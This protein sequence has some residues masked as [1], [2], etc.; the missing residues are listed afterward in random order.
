MAVSDDWTLAITSGLVIVGVAYS[1]WW[2]CPVSFEKELPRIQTRR[3]IYRLARNQKHTRL[4]VHIATKISKF[5]GDNDLQTGPELRAIATKVK[6]QQHKDT[7]DKFYKSTLLPMA[8]DG[9]YEVRIRSNSW[10]RYFGS[11]TCAEVRSIATD[12]KIS[13]IEPNFFWE[14]IQHWHEYRFVW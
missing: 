11:L 9:K 1:L 5:V 7:W 12:H 6:E 3:L 14:T 10:T 2:F 8:Q 13:F 4:P